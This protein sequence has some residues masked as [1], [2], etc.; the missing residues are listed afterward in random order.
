MSS[1][2][3]VE[4]C[5]HTQ[6]HTYTRTHT[7]SVDLRARTRTR[8]RT[9]T[10][11]RARARANTHTHVRARA[12]THTHTHTHSGKETDDIAHNGICVHAYTLTTCARRM[13]ALPIAWAHTRKTNTHTQPNTH[14]HT[15]TLTHLHARRAWQRFLPA[16]QHHAVVIFLLS[17][18]H[19]DAFT[20]SA[21]IIACLG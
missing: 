11:T 10:R 19:D 20:V 17:P 3:S 16:P 9:H 2:T 12:H 14:T 18:Q 13:A 7:T 1:S 8:T 21:G 5:A 6:T 15:H 4:T